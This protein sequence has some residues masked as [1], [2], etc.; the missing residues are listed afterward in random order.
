MSS[1]FTTI[2]FVADAIIAHI[3]AGHI[4]SNGDADVLDSRPLIDALRLRVSE[5]DVPWIL[6]CIENESDSA[7]G[8]A[9][10]LL[11][12]HSV[13][14]EVRQC[15]ENRW[16][17][18]SPYLKNRLIWRML[19]DPEL[20]QAL[21]REFFRFLI[22]E[23][24][25]F[26]DFNRSFYG[27]GKKGVLSLLSRIGD[28]S[29]PDSKKWIYLCCVPSVIEDNEAAKTLVSIGF[30]MSDPFAH[31]VARSLL[32]HFFTV[33][34]DR[35]RALAASSNMKVTPPHF[36]FIADA[37]VSYLRAGHLP[38]DQEADYLNRVP[39][40]DFLRIKIVKADLTWLLRVI[41]TRT[42]EL[43]A[44]CLSLLQKFAKERSIQQILR[45]KWEGA[46]AFLKAH[47][48]WR[49]LDD[50]DLPSEW[51]KR[52][53]DF[54]L[55]EWKTFQDVSLKFLGSP[56]TVVSQVLRRIGDAGFPDSKKWAYLCRVPE[57]AEDREAAK[58]LLTLG[59]SM[60]DPFCREVAGVLLQRFFRS[61]VKEVRA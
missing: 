37:V 45:E 52:L 5:T 40:I 35:N 20:P 32:E 56:Q 9:C 11:R 2:Q 50:P 12:A 57:V 26:V 44:F 43:A 27:D 39:I 61:E 22:D 18:A 25:T 48:M 58:A 30:T 41:E 16:Q 8:L 21:H 55:E 51:H 14:P 36:D 47:L 42:G 3:R 7:A 60:S 38:W 46:D 24:D 54:V 34:G 49:L 23:W 4:P 15:F 28:P 53:F 17:T 13:R 33:S 59:A 19:D 10:S 1:D 31:E 29:F 6:K